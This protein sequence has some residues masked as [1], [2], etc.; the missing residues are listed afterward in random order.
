MIVLLITA[1]VLILITGVIVDVL[2]CLHMVSKHQQRILY[3]SQRP[4][5]QDEPKAE[6]RRIAKFKEWADSQR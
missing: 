2:I 4:R 6:Q 5:K 1:L 3:K